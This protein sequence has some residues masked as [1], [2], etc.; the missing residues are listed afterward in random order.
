[1][2]AKKK[3]TDLRSIKGDK[4]LNFL[5]LLDQ[6]FKK[7]DQSEKLDIGN[8]TET[9]MFCVDKFEPEKKPPKLKNAM[10][11]SLIK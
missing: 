10:N 6:K 1:M 4:A 11:G 8:I 3:P 2:H 9:I 7:L 5:F